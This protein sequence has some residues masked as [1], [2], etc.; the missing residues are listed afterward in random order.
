M[1][2]A[3]AHWA[4]GGGIIGGGATLSRARCVTTMVPAAMSPSRFARGWIIE[5]TTAGTPSSR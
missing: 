1:S 2:A 3:C 5:A 4:R